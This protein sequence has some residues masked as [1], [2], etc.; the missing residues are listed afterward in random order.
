M[1]SRG[2]ATESRKA[3]G[4]VSASPSVPPEKRSA[5]EALAE[6][7]SL[8]KMK[9]GDLRVVP[10]MEVEFPR[11]AFKR[12][13]EKKTVTVNIDDLIAIEP[14][15]Y[16]PTVAKYIRSGGVKGKGKERPVVM[17]VNGQ[18]FLQD[19]NHRVVAMKLLGIRTVEVDLKIYGAR[20]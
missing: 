19:G 15:V 14:G 17:Q 13:V 18:L 1:G 10:P 6:L 2:A 20:E 9:E 7:A 8:P 4:V 3:K 11:L 5:A 12:V 16:P